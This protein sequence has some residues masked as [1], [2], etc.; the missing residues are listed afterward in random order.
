[1]ERFL[2]KKL[3]PTLNEA[4]IIP[5]WQAGFR[6]NHRTEHQIVRLV[7]QITSGFNK[8]QVT[9]AAFLDIERAYGRVWLN[10]LK[11]KILSLPIP[12]SLSKL[13]LSFL[14]HRSFFTQIQNSRSPI[15]NIL[16]GVPQ[17]SVL[18]P[19]LFNLYIS[20]IP[21]H[22]KTQL[23]QYAD[24]TTITCSSSFPLMAAR[25]VQEHLSLIQQWMTK[26]KIKINISKC[27]RITFKKGFKMA[28]KRDRLELSLNE[29]VIP[30]RSQEKFLGVILTRNLSWKPHIDYR[31]A[32]AT[33]AAYLLFPIINSRA[34]TPM[35]YKLLVYLSMIRPILT[36]GCIA[37]AYG[38]YNHLKRIQAFDNRWIK[39]ITRSPRITPVDEVLSAHKIKSL[40]YRIASALYKFNK[41]LPDLNNPC[42]SSIWDYDEKTSF[43]QHPHPKEALNYYKLPPT[44]NNP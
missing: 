38:P 41:K 28:K 36:Y 39:K 40:N 4:N 1:M 2:L 15:I 10:G 18:A 3:S 31:L 42:F 32:Q 12:S 20:D 14:S 11:F 37:W 44:T 9:V 22:P 16:A 5:H 7:E 25:R 26:W 19:F 27:A 21:S 34:N 43:T 24:D 6:R 13:L 23:Y 29:V 35:K 17:G 33:K 30:R 8:R